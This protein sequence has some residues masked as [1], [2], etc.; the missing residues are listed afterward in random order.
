[1]SNESMNS[2]VNGIEYDKT[3]DESKATKEELVKNNLKFV[4]RQAHKY[5]HC[6]PLEDLIQ[7]GNLGLMRAAETFDASRGI[8]FITYAVYHVKDRM[9]QA[10]RK[11]FPVKGGLGKVKMVYIDGTFANDDSHG[12]PQSDIGS[13]LDCPSSYEDPWKQMDDESTHKNMMTSLNKLSPFEKEV[14][15]TRFG[16]NNKNQATLHELAKKHK[17]SFTKIHLVEKSA[18]KK[19]KG[20]MKD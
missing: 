7:E 20:L 12:G 6:A 9:A 5:K 4:V 2:Y 11:N 15:E 8:K 13:F 18:L 14:I 10:M 1:M 17:C 3:M 16:I 19:M